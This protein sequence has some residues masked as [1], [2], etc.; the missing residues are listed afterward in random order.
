[1]IWRRKFH[2]VKHDVAFVL[3]QANVAVKAGNFDLASEYAHQV[4][5]IK[6]LSRN[7]KLS[8]EFV[9]IQTK[10]RQGQFAGVFDQLDSLFRRIPKRNVELK[11]RVGN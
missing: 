2:T 5:D 9:L 10:S 7:S 8:A 3:N 4:L 11:A 1:M 6:W